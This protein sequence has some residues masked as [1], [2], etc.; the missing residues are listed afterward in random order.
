M[1]RNMRRTCVGLLLL[2]A[3]AP[4]CIGG[5]LEDHNGFSR[6]WLT[7]DPEAQSRTDALIQKS[8][9]ASPGRSKRPP[10]DSAKTESTDQVL[11]EES[12]SS[13]NR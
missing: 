12:L 1:D 9:E 11:S 6:H 7:T 13:G 4:G 5:Y 3:A 10:A 8:Q 2:I